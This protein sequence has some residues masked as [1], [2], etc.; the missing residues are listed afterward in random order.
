MLFNVLTFAVSQGSCLNTSRHD[1]LTVQSSCNVFMNKNI[2]IM[3][4]PAMLSLVMP[5]KQIR[6]HIK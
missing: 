4:I 6:A 5:E 3:I 2:A 1:R